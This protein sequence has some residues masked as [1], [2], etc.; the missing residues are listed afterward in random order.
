VKGRGEDVTVTLRCNNACS[1]CPRPRLA[2][3]RVPPRALARVL[4]EVRKGG[5]TVVLSGGEATLLPGFFAIVARCRELGFTRIGLVSNGRRAS[6]P[7]FAAR[8]LSAGLRDI[9]VSVYSHLPA[10]HDGMTGVPGSCR[11]TWR[12]L[13]NLLLLA[14][15]GGGAC[16]IR[17]NLL[18]TAANHASLL[19]T[20]RRLARL[21]VPDVLVMDV[22]SED[23]RVLP[24][25]AAIRRVW[26]ALGRA[27]G[28][29]GMRV[30][31]RGYPPCLFEGKGASRGS[32]PGSWLTHE[33]M[34]LD[35]T[36][37]SDPDALARY[38]G[39][40]AKLFTKEALPCRRCRLSRR[41][42]GVQKSYL[43]RYGGK[44]LG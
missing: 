5:E 9:M 40:A 10:V 29:S 43:R 4:R 12:G 41:C 32:R 42:R 34:E 30:R 24:P 35:T 20:L 26:T 13:A 23:E 14:R 1:F 21:G 28:L 44:G 19:G 6:R 37:G 16:P 25:Y 38:L 31:L 2:N 27:Q 17:V 15:R 18:V 7:D 8:L 33:P 39:D 3:V 22:L 11:E 36:L